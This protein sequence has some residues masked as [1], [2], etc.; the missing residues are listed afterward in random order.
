MGTATAEERLA[1]VRRQIE[2]L[3]AKGRASTGEGKSRIQRQLGALREQEASVRAAAE[4]RADT[5]DGKFEQFEARLHVAQSA[6]AAE[7]SDDR[8]QF[9]AAVDDELHNWDTYFERLQ[10]QTALRAANTR[11]EAEAA[12]S[13]LRKRR[14]AVAKR[15]VDVRSTSGDSWSEQKKRIGAA[16]DELERKADEL[17]AQFT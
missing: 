11:E 16:R 9:A 5:F 3:E 13:D 14:N 17:A 4:Q 1:E 12:I 8:K 10:A 2:Q 15:L 6:I 7:L